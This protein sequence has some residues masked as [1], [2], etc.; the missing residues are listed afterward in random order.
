MSSITLMILCFK[1]QGEERDLRALGRALSTSVPCLG[2][3]IAVH[4]T[5]GP[6]HVIAFLG[7]EV[8]TVAQELR[9]FV[10]M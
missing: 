4:K 9:W 2:V 8:D 7:I 1:P 10:T 3:P 5:D 6:A